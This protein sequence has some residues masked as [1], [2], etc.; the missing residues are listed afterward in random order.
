MWAFEI[1]WYI[2][3]VALLEK[4]IK[5]LHKPYK[6]WLLKTSTYV[7]VEK[8]QNEYAQSYDFWI[9][10]HTNITLMKVALSSTISLNLYIVLSNVMLSFFSL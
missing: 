1:C 3:P 10:K 7:Y 8:K 9:N 5:G 2:E 4:Y 6:N